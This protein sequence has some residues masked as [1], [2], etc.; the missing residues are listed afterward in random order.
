MWFSPSDKEGGPDASV[1]HAAEFKGQYAAS[2]GITTNRTVEIIV[3][4]KYP[5]TPIDLYNYMYD[6]Y[7]HFYPHAALEHRSDVLYH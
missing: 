1:N 7:V 5:M 3:D 6:S 2:L 4:A